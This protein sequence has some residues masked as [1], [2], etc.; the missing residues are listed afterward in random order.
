MDDLLDNFRTLDRAFHL[1]I[2]HLLVRRIPCV[3]QAQND[4]GA[5]FPKVHASLHAN[6]IV[7]IT[8]HKL[9]HSWFPTRWRHEPFVF[10]PI[11]NAAPPH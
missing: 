10:R 9:G 6:P 7:T 11:V 5:A 4:G 2:K 8:G 3:S 1:E